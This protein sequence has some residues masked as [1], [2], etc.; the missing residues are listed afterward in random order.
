MNNRKAG[1]IFCAILMLLVM[2]LAVVTSDAKAQTTVTQL[3]VSC[4]RSRPVPVSDIAT[5][6]EIEAAKNDPKAAIDLFNKSP[7][8]SP[9]WI[10]YK[11]K[12]EKRKSSSSS[13]AKSST[14]SSAS[15]SV[16]LSTVSFN[17]PTQC[18]LGDKFTCDQID[19]FELKRLSGIETIEKDCAAGK[20]VYQTLPPAPGETF[21]VSTI[22]KSVCDPLKSDYIPAVVTQ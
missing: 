15:S 17:Q 21:T 20:V 13:S 6:K 14:A 1:F 7:C 19:H 12:I 16:R 9:A 11:A 10:T 18:A 5:A 3:T 8:D 2:A 22:V 4:D